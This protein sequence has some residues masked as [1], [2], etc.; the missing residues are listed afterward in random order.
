MKDIELRR[1]LNQ[2]VIDDKVCDKVQCSGNRAI[3]SPSIPYFPGVPCHVWRR[4]ELI[5]L[6]QKEIVYG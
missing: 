1:Y 3:C 2:A 4:T 6:L 5:N